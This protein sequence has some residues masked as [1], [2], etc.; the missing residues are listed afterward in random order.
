[1]AKLFSFGLLLCVMWKKALFSTITSLSLLTVQPCLQAYHSL[2]DEFF[3]VQRFVSL[4]LA[5]DIKSKDFKMGT[6]Y[7]KFWSFSTRYDFYDSFDLLQAKAKSQSF[8]W[9]HI[10]DVTDANDQPI[11]KVEQRFNPLFPTFDLLSASQEKLA[12]AKM[13]FWGTR[14]TLKDPVTKGIIATISRSF[15]RLRDYWTVNITDQ[16]L[17]Q[18]KNIDHRLFITVAA[19][20]TDMDRKSNANLLSNKKL[21]AE[22]KT[23]YATPNLLPSIQ[24]AEPQEEDFEKVVF[25]V[26]QAVNGEIDTSNERYEETTTLKFLQALHALQDS[27][28][29]TQQEKNAAA[30]LLQEKLEQLLSE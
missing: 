26:E 22:L 30:I 1:M 23:I 12:T 17:F 6:V 7:R 24:N 19:F 3:I 27:D 25:L 15:L 16:E 28:T 14:Y 4:T 29:L 2:P 11:G 10:F 9:L 8:S 20:Q 18:S 21:Q 13:N 5:L